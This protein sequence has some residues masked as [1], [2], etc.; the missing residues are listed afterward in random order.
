MGGH[1]DSFWGKVWVIFEHLGPFGT[2]SGPNL[3]NFEVWF[4]I[5]GVEKRICKENAEPSN[6]LTLTVFFRVFHLQLSE[7]SLNIS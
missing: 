5:L 6:L 2:I 1:L 7:I 4:V 3:S